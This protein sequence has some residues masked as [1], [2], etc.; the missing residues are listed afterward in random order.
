VAGIAKVDDPRLIL[1]GRLREK[2]D[3]QRRTEEMIAESGVR[4]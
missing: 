1:D 4:I 3:W 2:K